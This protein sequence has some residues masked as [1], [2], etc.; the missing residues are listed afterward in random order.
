M[1]IDHSAREV[2]ESATTRRRI[3]TTGAK[4]AY[5]APVIAASMSLSASRAGAISPQNVRTCSGPMAFGPFGWGGWSCPAGTHAIAGELEPAN[6]SV[7]SQEL[8]GPGFN[9]MP[10]YTYGPKETGYVVQNDN[11][12]ESINVCV[13][14]APG[15]PV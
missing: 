7:L 6:A 10:G 4:A 8:A 5:A 13:I 14:C 11:D 1:S 15:D 9:K 12:G 2:L 3:V